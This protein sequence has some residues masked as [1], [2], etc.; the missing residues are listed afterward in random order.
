MKTLITFGF[1]FAASLLAADPTLAVDHGL[2]RFNLNN[3]L[4]PSRNNRRWGWHD[5]GLLD[6]TFTVRAMGSVG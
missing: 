5:Q 2:P 1:S 6:E 3:T 4:G